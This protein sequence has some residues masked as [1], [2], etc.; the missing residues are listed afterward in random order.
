MTDMARERDSLPFLHRGSSAPAHSA[1]LVLAVGSG[2]GAAFAGCRPTGTPVLD[3]VYTAVFAALVTY[4]C[5]R[6]SKEALLIFAGVAVVMS[7]TWLEIPAVLALAVAFS[8]VFSDTPDDWRG[9]LVGALG[10]ETVVRWPPVAFHGSTALVAAVAALVPA[11]SARSRA[12]ARTRRVSSWILVGGLGAGVILTFPMLI[13]GLLSVSHVTSGAREAKVALRQV[14]DGT[15]ASA[16]GE[17]SAATTNFESASSRLG[18][19]WTELSRAVPVVA[20]QRQSLAVATAAAGQLTAEA[21][22]DAPALDYHQLDYHQGQ[23][24][25]GAVSAMLNPVRRLDSVMRRAEVQVDGVRT[26]WLVGPLQSRLSGLRGDLDRATATTDLAAQAIPVVPAMLG[27]DGPRHYFLA[28]MTPSE[29]RALGGIVGAYGELTAIDGHIS[30]TVSGPDDTFNA[31]LPANG[32]TLTGPADYLA[33]YG[34]FHPAQFIQDVTFSPDL[35]TVSQVIAQMAPQA[36]LDPIDGV[37]VMDPAGLAPLLRITGPVSVPGLPEPLTAQNAD[38]VLLEQ[39][40][41]LFGNI[42]TEQ[43]QRHD[44]LQ[45]VVKAA[46]GEILHG[47]LPGPRGLSQQLEPQ[48]LAGNIGFWSMHADEQPLV[49]RLHLDDAFPR[50]SGDDVLAITTQNA[51]ANKIDAY[52]HETISDRVSYNPGSGSTTAQVT[53]TLHNDAP[54]AGLP[55]IVIDNSTDGR[56]PVGAAYTWVSIYSPLEL[57][58]VFLDGTRFALDQGRE[59][60]LNVFSNWVTVPSG[61]TIRVEVTLTGRLRVG[62]PYQLELRLQPTANVVGASVSVDQDGRVSVWNPADR[63]DQTRA[64]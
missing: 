25:L 59:L 41:L 11:V 3:P 36:G 22:R 13:A 7:R 60:G 50:T 51:G 64:F 31:G 56:V 12:S 42:D 26:S 38:T 39:Q 32:A 53:L 17:L 23:I 62:H 55:P 16:T 5:S 18:S 61:S 58:S 8:S 15:A 43:A 29:S 28:F 34:Q 52:V 63:V 49:R 20:Q 37:L 48:V 6:A 46:F 57:S 27:A 54:S 24:D 30:L 21:E 14:E 44:L 19:W 10:V 35:P 40:Y 1:V 9:A 2:V 45:A 47:T 33:R 4:A